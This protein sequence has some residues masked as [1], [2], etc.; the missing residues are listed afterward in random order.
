MK[1]LLIAPLMLAAVPALAERTPTP[2]GQEAEIPFANRDGIQDY[3]ALDDRG[4]Y[5]RSIT[6]EWY[7]AR[8]MGR[9]ARLRSANTIG[10]ETPPGGTLDRTGALYAQG[11]RCQIDSLTRSEAP[12][13]KAKRSS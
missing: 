7:Y 9:C 10:F 4:L 5:I 2:I 3:R 8:T 11:W 13:R 6:G 12:P 1:A